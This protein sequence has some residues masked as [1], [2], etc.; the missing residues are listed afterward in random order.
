MPDLISRAREFA[1]SAHQHIEHRRK[2]TRQPYEVHLKAVARL[3]AE[4]TTDVRLVAAAWLHDTVE[5]T[6]ATHADIDAAF[7]SEIAKLVYD[8]TDVSRPGDG[9]RA[10]RKAIDREHLGQA[11]P[12]AQ[13]VKLADLIDNTSDICRHDEKFGRVFLLEA[14]Q[15][16]NV[17]DK[18]DPKL[19]SR[20]QQVISRY[21]EKLGVDGGAVALTEFPE[22]T[23]QF[24]RHAGGKRAVRLFSQAF[25]AEDI[26][27]PLKS[28]DGERRVDDVI[29]LMDLQKL[30]IAGVRQG[31][32]VV[33]AVRRNDLSETDDLLGKQASPISRGQIVSGS[34]PLSEIGMVLSRHQ[35][36]FVT[37][38][39]SI[40]GVITRNDFEKPIVRMWLFGV[41]TII[42][43][44]ITEIIRNRWPEDSWVPLV[45]EKRLEQAR[46]IHIE[47]SRI[48]QYSELLDCLQ[49][50]DKGKILISDQEQL[51]D[52]GFQSQ[53]AAKKTIKDIESL[54]NNL[55]HGQSIVAHDWAQI[56]R[57]TRNIDS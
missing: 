45:S 1:T 25:V 50:S 15:L 6:L 12:G 19:F 32:A 40:G 52:L 26:A 28:F 36:C 27:E 57:F 14:L 53:G 21:A 30:E 22:K 55:A 23:N 49:V 31:G 39:E 17:L 3:V 42:E 33:A 9:N 29:S 44:S 24:T 38:L 48:Q 20:A 35:Y 18:G 56:L 46:N 8:L 51:A 13:T 4:V 2:Y 47:R 37:T 11:S 41:L 34:C 43:M 10:D 5:D 16:L 54:R 7:G